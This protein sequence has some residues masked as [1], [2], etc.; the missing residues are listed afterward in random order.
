MSQRKYDPEFKKETVRLIVEKGRS[1][2]SVAK[3]LGISPNTVHGWLRQFRQ[4][5]DNAFPG[6]GKLRPEDEELRQMRRRIADLEEE[7]SILKKAAAI[8]ARPQK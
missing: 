4:H 6:K 8:F 2:S 5:Q 1:A 7:C 3:D